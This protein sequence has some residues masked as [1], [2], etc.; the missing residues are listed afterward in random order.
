MYRPTGP[1]RAGVK[2]L[3][4]LK[5]ININEAGAISGAAGIQ[6]GCGRLRVEDVL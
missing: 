2:D 1:L 6:R 3:F 5:L 4:S